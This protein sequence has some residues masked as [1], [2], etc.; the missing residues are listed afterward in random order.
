MSAL[1]AADDSAHAL[2]RYYRLH[3]G[4][5]DA[6][7]W[8]FL[9]GRN[10]MVER[11]AALGPQRVLEVGCGTGRNLARLARALPAAELIGVDI[12]PAMLDRARTHLAPLGAR[13]QLHAGGLPLPNAEGRFDVVIAAYVLSMVDEGLDALLQQM[14]AACAPGGRL[15]IVDFESTRTPGFARWMAVNHVR[16]EDR[17][18]PRLS[19]LG[20][21]EHAHGEG[22]YGGVWRW[23]SQCVRVA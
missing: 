8:A 14:R 1:P 10:A 9:F 20:V 2:Q 5:Y 13:C 19:Q 23:F 17:I 21:I 11:V 15:V 12:S 7:R 16:L 6:T 22:A 3:A 18:R 4:I